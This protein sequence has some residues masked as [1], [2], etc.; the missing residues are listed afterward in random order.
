MT[1]ETYTHTPGFV[2]IMRTRIL[3]DIADNRLARQ[4]NNTRR[5]ENAA[6]LKLLTKYPPHR[7]EITQQTTKFITYQDIVRTKLDRQ[8]QNLQCEYSE[9]VSQSKS[10]S[11]IINRAYEA[12]Y[13]YDTVEATAGIQSSGFMKCITKLFSQNTK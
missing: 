5:A 3:N 12:A 9:L 8:L 1:S 10:E 11:E 4:I 13:D 6:I 2:Q 7:S